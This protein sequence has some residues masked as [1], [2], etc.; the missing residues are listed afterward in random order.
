MTNAIRDQ[1]P[2][3]GS[4]KNLV[5]LDNAATTQK[6]ASVITAMN[7][8][9]SK[10]NANIHRGLYELSVK[11]TEKYSAARAK[12]ALFINAAPDEIVLTRGAT[13]AINLVAAS[14]GG[15]TLRAGDEVL[16]TAMEH[17]ANIV[18]W[19]EICKKTGAVLKVLPITSSGQLDLMRL[20]L[21]LTKKTKIVAVTHVSNVLGTINLIKKIIQRAHAVGARVLV[22]GAQAIAHLNVDVADLD[23]DFY[24]FSGHK[25]YGPTGIGVLFGKRELLNSMPPYQTGGEMIREVSF[26]STTYADAPMRFEAGTPN[27]AGAIGLGAAVDFLT[28]QKQLGLFTQERQLTNY[29]REQLKTIKGLRVLSNA[30]N[31][32][33]TNGTLGIFSFVIEGVHPHDIAQVL[34]QQGIAVRAGHHCAMPL[35]KNLGFS[36]STR[37]SLAAYNT[38]EDIDCA[39]AALRS[40]TTMFQK[41]VDA[42]V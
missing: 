11:A 30:A 3:F 38:T 15:S 6:P 36:A 31:P 20:D 2:I 19:Q 5:Y 26:A 24:V 23:C 13:E 42:N 21:E 25:M 28:K 16:I 17:H 10:D 18:P 32:L 12:V 22:D 14:F 35:H 9:Y 29:C 27:I 7:D 8:F 37:I 34:D 33:A 1:F 39:L 41:N 4:N 40:V